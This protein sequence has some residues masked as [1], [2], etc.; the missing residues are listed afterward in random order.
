MSDLELI[1]KTPSD[2][3]VKKHLKIVFT[4]YQKLFGEVC[5]GCPTKIAGYINRIKKFQKT[6]IMSQEKSNFTLSGKSVILVPGTSKVYS[7]ANLT[8]EVAIAFIRKN[9]NRRALFSKVPSNLSELLEGGS[10][11]G[12]KT[13][14]DY[15]VAQLKAIYPEAKGKNKTELIKDIQSIINQ[16]AI[17]AEAEEKE[18]QNANNPNEEEE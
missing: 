6:D 5:T 3:L 2:E 11:D 7:N 12:V 4:T 8:D 14:N 9:A 15:T 10:E 16:A 17:N 18:K 13:L 1:Q